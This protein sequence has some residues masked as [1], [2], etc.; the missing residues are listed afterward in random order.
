MLEDLEASKL[1]RAGNF[2]ETSMV[3]RPFEFQVFNLPSKG[4]YL[5]F[6]SD[7]GTSKCELP[8]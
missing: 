8:I 6:S 4:F 5:G 2:V 1:E 7:I 3:K